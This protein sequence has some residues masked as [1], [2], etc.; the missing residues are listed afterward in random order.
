MALTGWTLP[1]TP[2]G[3]SATVAPPPWHYSGEV[4]CVEYTASPEA[5]AALAPAGFEPEGDGSIAFVC[6]DW[7]SSSDHDPRVMDDPGRGQYLEAFLVF[8]G[9]FRDRSVS[10][11]PHIWVTSE[12]SLLRGLIQGF[13]KK[14]AHIAMT[15]AIQHGKGGS[16]KAGGERF[17]AQVSGE[18]YR[19]ITATLTLEQGPP[20]APPAA[21]VLPPLHT[22]L[23]PGFDGK[24]SVHELSL[25]RIA[26]PQVS[27]VWSGA[28]SLEIAGSPY[29]ELDLLKP[30][31][32]GRGWLA[33]VSFSVT[34]ADSFLLGSEQG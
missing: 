28:A 22:R 27:D 1:Q 10:R 32:V 11:V 21:V 30:R 14:L 25:G 12:L 18:G 19:L 17:A 7:C 8:A 33:T 16:R 3:L 6:C 23:W 9:R 15:R 29:E 2:T 20:Q 5:I 34:G 26:D 24:P 13:P 4:L 31:T